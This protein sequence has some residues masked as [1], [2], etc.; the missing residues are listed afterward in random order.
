[1]T[2][3]SKYILSITPAALERCFMVADILAQ[4]YE[5][6][7]TEYGL[8]GLALE[9]APLHIVETPLLY[10]Q[11]SGGSVYQPSCEFFKLRREIQILSEKYDAPLVLSSFIHRHPM[12]CFL[13]LLDQNFLERFVDHTAATVTF[14][15]ARKKQIRGFPCRCFRKNKQAKNRKP[16][17]ELTVEYALGFSII[18]N[19]ERE[20]AI[21]AVR[22][23]YCPL[24]E[25]STVKRVSAALKVQPE[26]QLSHE[27]KANLRK[28]LE[29][30]VEAKIKFIQSKLEDETE[31][32][33]KQLIVE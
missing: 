24:C 25:K 19:R 13:S 30:E 29:T 12:Q 21:Y 27:E 17:E 18:V 32:Y 2:R 1:M 7:Y 8:I 9:S 22:K 4:D 10:Q 23:R 33:G 11:V 16:A 20:F 31:S 14:R 26:Y 15:E 5:R 28:Q 6:P 3:R